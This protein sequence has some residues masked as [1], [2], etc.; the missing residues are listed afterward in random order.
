MKIRTLLLLLVLSVIIGFAALNW[1]TFLAPTTLSLGL[2]DVQAPLGLV[3][4]GLLVFV[5]GMFLVFVLYLQ[6][7]VLFDTRQHAKELQT[8]RNLADQAEASRFTELR[9][10][11]ELELKKQLD[12]DGHSRAAVLTR[13]DQME[14]TL[15]LVVEQSGNSLAASLGELEDRLDKGNK[16]VTHNLLA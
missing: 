11:L 12:Q 9:S 6:T 2:A 10:F 3:M 1:A 7:T 16:D 5:T 8:N 15:R 13:I 14:G 4:L